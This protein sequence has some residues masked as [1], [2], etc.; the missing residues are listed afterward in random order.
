[1]TCSESGPTMSPA[2]TCNFC[3]NCIDVAQGQVAQAP[4]RQYC[5]DS[6]LVSDAIFSEEKETKLLGLH[7]QG[8]SADLRMWALQHLAAWFPR[9]ANQEIKEL[10]EELQ[11]N[12]TIS[13]GPI[14]PAEAVRG[15]HA[16]AG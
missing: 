16:D 2:Q 15:P 1:M 8:R 10:K 5:Q 7:S 9:I 13:P 11:K 3:D 14:P 12:K 6:R 4:A